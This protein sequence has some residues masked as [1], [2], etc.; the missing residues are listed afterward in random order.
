MEAIR[1]TGG[2]TRPRRSTLLVPE[3]T[4]HPV[5]PVRALLPMALS[6]LKWKGVKPG[7]LGTQ[8]PKVICLACICKGLGACQSLF[9]TPDLKAGREEPSP[10]Q[11]GQQGLRAGPT[12]RRPRVDTPRS[13]A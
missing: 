10:Q 7:D 5:K 8:R 9:Q 13:L 12:R 2:P 11:Y 6:R 3:S 1:N 4:Q